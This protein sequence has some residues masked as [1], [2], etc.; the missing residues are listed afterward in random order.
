MHIYASLLYSMIT[1]IHKDES[2][3][4][5]KCERIARGVCVMYTI[6]IHPR[7]VHISIS[8]E[9]QAHLICAATVDVWSWNFCAS[10]YLA[11]LFSVS[12]SWP[13]VA[14][15]HGFHGSLTVS[16]YRGIALNKLE[17]ICSEAVLYIKERVHGV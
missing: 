2:L 16:T 8:K 17:L 13:I 5:C 4:I 12:L 14:L 15:Q 3:F 11:L 7:K 1:I 10:L 6:Y 9:L